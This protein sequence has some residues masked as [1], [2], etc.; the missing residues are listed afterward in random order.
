MT[1][2][3]AHPGRSRRIK[4]SHIVKQLW[5]PSD[6]DADLEQVSRLSETTDSESSWSDSAPS[7]DGASEVFE[8]E[9][10]EKG[11]SFAEENLAGVT[12]WLEAECKEVLAGVDWEPEFEHLQS[13]ETPVKGMDTSSLQRIRRNHGPRSS[14]FED[15]LAPLRLTDSGRAPQSSKRPIKETCESMEATLRAWN[16]HVADSASD[17]TSARKTLMKAL[18]S[19][20]NML[21]K[22]LITRWSAD[23]HDDTCRRLLN[24]IH[25]YRPETVNFE[26]QDPMDLLIII[27]AHLGYAIPDIDDELKYVM[28]YTLVKERGY[29]AHVANENT[30]RRY[31]DKIEDAKRQ[32]DVAEA[33]KNEAKLKAWISAGLQKNCDVIVERVKTARQNVR[34][35][36]LE[37]IQ[38][39]CVLQTAQKLV[40]SG[41][42]K[43]GKSPSELLIPRSVW[44]PERAAARDAA[45]AK[46]KKLPSEHI[47]DLEISCKVIARVIDDMKDV[48]KTRVVT[49]AFKFAG[50]DLKNVTEDERHRIVQERMLNPGTVAMMTDAIK[51]ISEVNANAEGAGESVG[52]MERKMEEMRT[53][54]TEV[55]YEYDALSKLVNSDPHMELGGG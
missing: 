35:K 37:D 38:E 31:E 19:R 11:P 46:L 39:L 50:L 13:E 54:V 28:L 9:D 45:D 42:I 10:E 5:Q 7:N 40:L 23:A 44:W 33:A 53:A 18:R 2:T 20:I 52:K 14:Q 36:G 41:R 8:E 22:A 3:S 24:A 49:R 1:L 15:L 29:S 26:N 47:D 34:L 12:V 27:I 55:Q 43:D 51:G 25:A 6:S 21:N 4:R 30:R 16:Q 17:N 32:G 48:N